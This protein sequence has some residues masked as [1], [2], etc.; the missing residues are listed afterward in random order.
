M[1]LNS[2]IWLSLSYILTNN[3]P[4]TVYKCTS[5]QGITFSQQPCEN[6]PEAI[7]IDSP[8]A[9]SS[10]I[11]KPKKTPNL[12]LEITEQQHQARLRKQI[13]SAQYRIASNYKDYLKQTKEL[14]KQ[15]GRLRGDKHKTQKKQLAQTRKLLE[16][17]YRIQLKQEKRKIKS[18]QKAIAKLKKQRGHSEH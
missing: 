15:S 17:K 18:L 10:A 6:N 2:I 13:K 9:A 8:P 5:P 14:D 11:S 3:S 4:I 12:L 1:D 7:L 16:K